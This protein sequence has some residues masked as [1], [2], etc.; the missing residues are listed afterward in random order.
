MKL[1]QKSW[2]L[3]VVAVLLLL[4]GAAAAAA[5][6]LEVSAKSFVIMDAKT[7]QM[8]LSLN[9]QLFYPPAST[10]KVMT[11]MYV[12]ERLK[13]DDKVVISPNAAAA[14]PSKIKVRPGEVYTVKELLYALLLS[15]PTTRP[16]PWPRK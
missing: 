15:W 10:L 3:G 12:V 1:S 14:P 4:A 9:P 13:M 16:G 6:D 7:G 5:E 8:L 11:A 2:I